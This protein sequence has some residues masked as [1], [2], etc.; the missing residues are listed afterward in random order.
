LV[1]AL[2]DR[3]RIAPAFAFVAVAACASRPTPPPEQPAPVESSVFTPAN[4][5]V[6]ATDPAKAP[7]AET[8]LSTSPP[9]APTAS[10][11]D[12]PMSPAPSPAES[13]LTPGVRA[14]AVV[15]F[16]Q[17]H[18]TRIEAAMR[19]AYPAI[20]ECHEKA[21]DAGTVEDK[22]TRV[23]LNFEIT[24]QGR[25]TKLTDDTAN[26]NPL[27]SS[28]ILRAVLTVTFQPPKAGVVRVT[29]PLELT[30]P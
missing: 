20:R 27:A 17:L 5:V 14:G 13:E 6:V 26:L 19:T 21:L 10:G 4:G 8:A 23:Q 15:V 2:M 28:C 1:E 22:L 9:P 16:G 18:A 3:F 11:P 12:D 24:E 29:Y 25:I 7:P 30:K